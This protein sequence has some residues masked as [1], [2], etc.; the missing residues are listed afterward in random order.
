MSRRFG[1]VA[2]VF[3]ALLAVDI[4]L[5]YL[6]QTVPGTHR[7]RPLTPWDGVGPG[8]AALQLVVIAFLYIRSARRLGW[9]D[10][11]VPKL[12]SPIPYDK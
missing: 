7:L 4:P 1:I 9:R 12:A 2:T 5:L 6:L 11:P 10:A 3:S 8:I